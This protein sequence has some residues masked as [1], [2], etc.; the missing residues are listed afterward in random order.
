[1][2]ETKNNIR[3]IIEDF[4]KSE[5]IR[6]SIDNENN[7]GLIYELYVGSLECFIQIEYDLQKEGDEYIVVQLFTDIDD[8]GFSL[9]DQTWENDGNCGDIVGAI[10]E[11]IDETKRINSIVN[12]I[13]KRIEQ[14]EEICEEEGMDLNNFLTIKYDFEK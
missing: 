13:R 7:F 8:N 2:K 6:Y 1:M 14:I 11:L 5:K 10:G 9:Y 12:K 4:L 3:Q